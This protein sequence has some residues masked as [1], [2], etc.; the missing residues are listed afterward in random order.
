FFFDN[1]PRA[2]ILPITNCLPP[3]LLFSAIIKHHFL[4]PHSPLCNHSSSSHQNNNKYNPSHSPMGREA[5][6]L[7]KLRSHVSHGLTKST[8]KILIRKPSSVAVLS[9]EVAGMMSKLLLLHSSV[10]DSSILRLKNEAIALDGVRK[11][12]SNDDAFLLRLA[13]A[14][15]LHNLR[16][17]AKAVASYLS[18]KCDDPNLRCFLQLFDDFAERGRDPYNWV[19]NAKELELLTKKLDRQIA[20][21]SLL[22]RELEALSALENG[23]RKS[24]QNS[25]HHSSKAEILL[26]EQI[27]FESQQKIAW[28][29]QE[30]KSAKDKSLWNRSFDSVTL[31]LAKLIFTILARIKLVFGIGHGYIATSLPRSL[32]TNS[33][34]VFPSSDNH[35][36]DS[37][38]ANEFFSKPLRTSK[39]DHHHHTRKSISNDLPV[40]GEFFESNTQVLNPPAGTLGASAL[41]LHYSNL[42][43]VLEKMVKSPHLVGLDARDDLYGMLPTSIRAALRAR[44]RGIGFTA[45]DP[46]LAEEWRDALG[47]I[48]GWLSPLGHN[49]IKWQSERSF[50]QHNHL[51]PKTNVL[52]L[53]TLHFANK[54]KTE[55]AITELLV[56]LNYI[57]R[58]E[59]EMNAKA[60]FECYSLINGCSNQQGSA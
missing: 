12:V 41:A 18:N 32:S 40:N 31:S 7:S 56:G 22:F 25:S 30:V 26:R 29:R 24:H 27:I 38:G 9:F 8:A 20:A 21:T 35:H 1:N 14:E 19:L 49:M 11:I 17:I 44:L 57:W 28:Q 55:A 36:N 45:T 46:Q 60:L 23:L 3:S 16:L 6:W 34:L 2:S 50:E 39:N 4:L 13:C 58:F 43:I 42:I 52:L 54:E 5:T 53:Q 47:R 37:S 51:G 59:R 15:F 48:L 33:A 10:S